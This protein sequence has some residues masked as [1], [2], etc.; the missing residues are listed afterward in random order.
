ML[1][2]HFH[3]QHYYRRL[4]A[5]ASSAVSPIHGQIVSV[6]VSFSAV[7]RNR[8]NTL[9]HSES[10]REKTAL[11][12]FGGE[13]IIDRFVGIVAV[14]VVVDVVACV[15]AGLGRFQLCCQCDPTREKPGI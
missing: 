10:H 2:H 12:C 9:R 6:V 1:K 11:Y 8:A 7:F 15:G 3:H 4:P 14:A 13:R 5:S